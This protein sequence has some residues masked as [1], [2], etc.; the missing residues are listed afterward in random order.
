M[1]LDTSLSSIVVKAII[2]GPRDPDG[3]IS[4]YRWWYYPNSDDT[5]KEGFKITPAAI[6]SVTFVIPKP[7]SP[8]EY[9]FVVEAV[10]ND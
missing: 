3:S 7:G 10:D 6:T 1:S 4:Y 5:R 8:T 9:A 2:Q